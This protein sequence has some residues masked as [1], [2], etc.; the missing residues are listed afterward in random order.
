MA[1]SLANRQ[2]FFSPLGH[3]DIWLQ[4]SLYAD[5]LAVFVALTLLDLHVLLEVLQM[6]GEA[7]LFN[8]LDKCLAT[9]IRTS[10]VHRNTSSCA[11]SDRVA[12][13]HCGIAEF[14][15]RSQAPEG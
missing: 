14:L 10:G 8:N 7:S 13:L 5:D 11:Q 15:C 3:T 1:R 12:H 9:P 6:F 2:G 4:T